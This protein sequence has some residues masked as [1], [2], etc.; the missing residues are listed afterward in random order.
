MRSLPWLPTPGVTH[1]LIANSEAMRRGRSPGRSMI[2]ACRVGERVAFA[3]KN[4]Q[5]NPTLC[6]TLA[7]PISQLADHL[8]ALS[9]QVTSGNL[10]GI[11]SREP[12]VSGL[13][14]AATSAG[15][16]VKETTNTT[17]S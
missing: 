12:L 15:I 13:M 16:P 6:T 9:S 11:G 17:G 2:V 7:K 14:S 3:T 5:A 8:S 10:A 1:P 4:V